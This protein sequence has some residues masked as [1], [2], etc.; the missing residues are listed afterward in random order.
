MKETNVEISWWTRERYNTTEKV[1][2]DYPLSAYCIH[3]I[4]NDNMIIVVEV[5]SN[6]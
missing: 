5:A 2:N 6:L 1:R 3:C 4:K